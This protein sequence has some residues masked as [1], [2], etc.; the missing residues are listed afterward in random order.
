MQTYIQILSNGSAWVKSSRWQWPQMYVPNEND[1]CDNNLHPEY[2]KTDCYHMHGDKQGVI[3]VA[4]DEH[5]GVWNL[6]QLQCLSN[7]FFTL[8]SK[9]I[10]NSAIL[11]ICEWRAQQRGKPFHSWR[12]GGVMHCLCYHLVLS[13]FD[14]RI[15]TRL[16]FKV[17]FLVGNM[18]MCFYFLSFLHAAGMGSR[19]P[20]P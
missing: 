11:A 3:T 2:W 5:R 13:K 10:S 20:S 19:N 18:N 17:I 12:H 1:N 16:T 14:S 7:H 15:K 6:W 8:A 4:S 9:K